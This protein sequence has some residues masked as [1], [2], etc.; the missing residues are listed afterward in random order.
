MNPPSFN[1]R[2]AVSAIFA[3]DMMSLKASVRA[4]AR[5]TVYCHS[6]HINALIKDEK[7]QFVVFTDWVRS[8]LPLRVHNA[9]P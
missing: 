7:R 2:H 4:A 5:I 3:D 9:T 6:L 1:S 8:R